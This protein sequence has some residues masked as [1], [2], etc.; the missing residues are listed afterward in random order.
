V[1]IPVPFTSFHSKSLGLTFS[2]VHSH[3]KTSADLFNAQHSIQFEHTKRSFTSAHVLCSSFNGSSLSSLMTCWVHTLMVNIPP[4]GLGLSSARTI[5][6]PAGLGLRSA[7][8]SKY[9]SR[10][11][12]AHSKPEFKQDASVDC[13]ICFHCQI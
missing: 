2:R 6:L 11:W 12:L 4:A 10:C 7:N 5:N 9:V 1:V 3:C 13:Q 8:S